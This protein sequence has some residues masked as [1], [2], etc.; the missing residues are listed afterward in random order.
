MDENE[1]K[2]VLALQKA[3]IKLALED[4]EL[5]ALQAKTATKLYDAFKAED[6][7]HADSVKLT[8]ACMSRGGM[9]K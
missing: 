4:D 3:A 9:L 1:I 6:F 2:E 8:L 5:I 7:A